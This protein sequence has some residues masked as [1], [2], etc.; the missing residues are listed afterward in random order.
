MR[1]QLAGDQRAWPCSRE[2]ECVDQHQARTVVIVGS[3]PDHTTSCRLDLGLAAH[4]LLHDG[5]WL[6]SDLQ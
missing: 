4:S 5:S 3:T 2:V 6:S 1:G